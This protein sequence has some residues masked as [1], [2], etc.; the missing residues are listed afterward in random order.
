[1]SK[2]Q[3]NNIYG[4]IA[5]EE[6][7]FE[8]TRLE[9][10]GKFTLRVE[11][12]LGARSSGTFVEKLG[13]VAEDVVKRFGVPD[14]LLTNEPGSV[15]KNGFYTLEEIYAGDGSE[16]NVGAMRILHW[17]P[18]IDTKIHSHDLDTPQEATTLKC[19]FIKL[20][21]SQ[22]AAETRY[23]YVGN[24]QVR[25]W[26]I[27]SAEKNVVTQDRSVDSDLF[28]HAFHTGSQ[29]AVTLNV[30]SAKKDTPP[31]GKNDYIDI[32]RENT[33][34]FVKRFQQE[35]RGEEVGR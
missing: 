29:G 1:M 15:S 22:D 25:L 23:Q 35:R 11:A 31:K 14:I 12:S 26:E 28:I 21:D 18:N 10:K 2:S 6:A 20:D 30:Y 24:N 4:K 5:Q 33:Q 16:G 27:R 17:L 19:Q 13:I 34:S 3:D 9:E 7:Q 32:E 8:I